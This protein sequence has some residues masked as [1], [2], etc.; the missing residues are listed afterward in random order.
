ALN[1]LNSLNITKDIFESIPLI[2]NFFGE[3]RNI[4]FVMQKN[5]NTKDLKEYYRR[6]QEELLKDNL[7]RWFIDKRNETVKENP[8]KLEKEISVYAY[9]PD[10]CGEIV[11]S[12]LNIDNDIPLETLEHVI[13]AYLMKYNKDSDIYFSIDILFKENGSE[14]DIYS[15]IKNGIIIMDNFINTVITDY[16]CNCLKCVKIIENIKKL[17]TEILLKDFS[18]SWDYTIE[19][20][21]LIWGQ[22]IEMGANDKNGNPV[23]M[24]DLRVPIDAHLPINQ[25]IINDDMELFQYYAS[26]HYT[27]FLL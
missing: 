16:P 26:M 5:F 17:K 15:R 21:K 2:D 13:K 12:R 1:S 4:T 11:D 14:I 7:L 22:Q 19:N 9:L 20:D 27:I 25:N 3:F 8:F 23:L 24:S 6:K 10:F 18:F